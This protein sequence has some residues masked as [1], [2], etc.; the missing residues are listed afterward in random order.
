MRIIEQNEKDSERRGSFAVSRNSAAA[1]TPR[2]PSSAL[3]VALLHVAICVHRYGIAL[4]A[5]VLQ[6]VAA[7]GHLRGDGFVDTSQGL[8][9]EPLLKDGDVLMG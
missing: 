2:L 5:S 9:S 3:R 6:F 1:L 7:V 8:Y 4:A